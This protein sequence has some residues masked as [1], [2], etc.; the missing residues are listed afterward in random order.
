MT[1]SG[2]ELAALVGMAINM[3]A[4]DGQV[5][6]TEREVIVKELANFGVDG[7]QAAQILM[8]AKDMEASESIETI[9]QMDIEQKKYV[10][11]FLAAIMI[12]DGNIEDSEVSLWKFVSMICNLPTMDLAEA[13]EF[14]TKN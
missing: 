12:A 8:K 5:D 10:T 14:W 6:K 3:A 13:L 7:F 11:G 1:Y 9:S 2:K 4:A